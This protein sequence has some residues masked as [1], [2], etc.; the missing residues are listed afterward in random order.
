MSKFNKE[1]PTL[2]SSEIHN[3]VK[4]KEKNCKK[5]GKS[6]GGKTVNVVIKPKD[7]A[8]YDTEKYYGK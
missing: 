7:K 5:C 2:K 1:N 4:C 3:Y 6:L 8:T